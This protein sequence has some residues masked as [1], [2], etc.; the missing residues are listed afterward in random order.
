MISYFLLTVRTSTPRSGE[1]SD[2]EYEQNVSI[3]TL[4]DLSDSFELD[5][6]DLDTSVDESEVDRSSGSGGRLG[7]IQNFTIRVTSSLF[8]KLGQ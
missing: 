6:D 7:Q 3:D 5:A 2:S 8:S 4:L 1:D